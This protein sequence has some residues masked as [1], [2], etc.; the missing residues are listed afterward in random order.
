MLRVLLLLLPVHARLEVGQGGEGLGEG[1]VLRSG[2]LMIGSMVVVRGTVV[3][4]VVVVRCMV[5][6]VL[7]AMIHGG[8]CGGG[9]A[10]HGGA[11]G[12]HGG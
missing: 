2:F 8:V 7:L 10:I 9:G 12:V 11:S 6:H 1:D 5:V 4:V 3:H